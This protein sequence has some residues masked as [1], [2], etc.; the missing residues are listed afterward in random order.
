MSSNPSLS[1]VLAAWSLDLNVVLG[2]ALTALI[3]L[4][5]LR[6]LSRRGRL[7]RSVGPHHVLL[8]A[9]GLLSIVL[10][11]ESPVDVLSSRLLT[12]HMVQHMLLLFLA[13][14]LL[15]LGKPIPVLVVGAPRPIVRWLAR[16]HARRGW[17]RGLTR[18]L[19]TPYFA[20][21][22][23]IGNMLIW[24]LPAC[25]DAALRNDGV[26]HLEHL[27][28]LVTG[29]MFWWVIV[30][31]YPGRPRLAHGW[32]VLY[33]LVSMVPGTALGML[34]IFAGSSIYPFYAALPRMW[35]MSVV[36][37]QSFAGTI[38]MVVG[39]FILICAAIPLFA[40]MMER[41]EEMELARF[42]RS[43]PRD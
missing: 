26:H 40:G 43:H 32:R 38:M 41:L 33:I 22:A 16:G 12:A 7:R 19:T 13:P 23:F 11:L 24:H 30:Q 39:D 37:D 8:F 29:I 9:L 1:T 21:L 42:A 17:F 35:D 18:L 25:Y 28:F 27:C 4:A 31:P 20:W 3:Y 15:L 34:F 14:P 10:A 6:E 5:G 36:T 2:V